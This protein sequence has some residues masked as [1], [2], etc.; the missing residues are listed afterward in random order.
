MVTPTQLT[1][2][3]SL[4]SRNGACSNQRYRKV[5]GLPPIFRDRVL[6]GRGAVHE[7][8]KGLVRRW[9]G[10]QQEVA[11]GR[12]NGLSDRLTGEQVVAEIDRPQGLYAVPVSGEP[13]LGGVALAI[14]L[15]GA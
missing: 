8:I 15:L 3:A 1:S 4:P 9:L 11:I 13:A 2:I 14:L 10:G 6:L 12:R 7:V 5:S